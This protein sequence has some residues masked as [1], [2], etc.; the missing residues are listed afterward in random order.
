MAFKQT[1]AL[2]MTGLEILNVRAQNLAGAPGTPTAGQFWYNTTTGRIEFRGAAANIDPTARANHTGTQDA[3]TTLTNLGGVALSSL[4]APT[5][6]VALNAQKLTNVA[7]AT[8][9]TDGANLQ[10]VTNA[11]AALRLNTIT[12]GADVA[13]SGFKLTG[14]GT[15]VA[16]TDGANVGNI[17]TALATLK[18]N[19]LATPTANYDISDYYITTTA[20]APAA[21]ALVPRSYV[22]G[23]INGTDWKAAVRVA[24]TAA[25]GTLSGLLTVDGVT[26][27]AGDRILVKNE[28]AGAANGLYVAA[29]GAWTRA[30]DAV[31]GTLTADAA[32]FVEEGTVN[33]DSQWRLTT[34]NPITVGTTALTFAQIGAATSYTNGTGLT[35]TGSTFAIDTATVVRKYSAT[36]AGGATTEAITHGLGTTDVTIGVYEVSTGNEIGCDKTRTS[37]NVVTLGFAVAPTAGQYRV[38]V[39]A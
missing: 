19:N 4:G 15:G 1:T 16:A 18:L 13:F 7:L 5:A 24:T 10:N 28:A 30:A 20:S 27:V 38:V 35:L 2:D 3:A 29:T 26:L 33:A 22:D 6:A 25:L 21:N 12:A 17:T 8:V 36:L 9:N 11:I 34:N 32:V 14:V 37:V 23:L 31:Q 39:H